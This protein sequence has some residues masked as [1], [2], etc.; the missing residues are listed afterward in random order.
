M[1]GADEGQAGSLPGGTLPA[2]PHSSFPPS[3]LQSR[4]SVPQAGRCP[5]SCAFVSPSVK[6]GRERGRVSG[7]LG[8][9][10]GPCGRC[11]CPV[12]SSQGAC[13]WVRIPPSVGQAGN[14]QTLGTQLALG[15]SF[16]SEWQKVIKSRWQQVRPS[17]WLPTA[18]VLST[19]WELIPVIPTA[20]PSPAIVSVV[21]T[22]R[23]RP[24]GGGQHGSQPGVP[25]CQPWRQ[26]DGRAPGAPADSRGLRGGASWLGS[27]RVS[28]LRS[29]A[30]C[31]VA[32]EWQGPGAPWQGPGSGEG[33]QGPGVEG[34]RE[35]FKEAVLCPG[36]RESATSHPGARGPGGWGRGGLWGPRALSAPD[37][38]WGDALL[39]PVV[40]VLRECLRLG[41]RKGP[42]Q[43]PWASSSHGLGVG[44]GMRPSCLSKNAPAQDAPRPTSPHLASP[45][46]RLWV[47]AGPPSCGLGTR[48]WEDWQCPVLYWALPAG[49]LQHRS[50]PQTGAQ[51]G[52]RPAYCAHSPR[53]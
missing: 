17:C 39:S 51:H 2:P 27:P 45:G 37:P 9:T 34:R 28:G 15:P 41:G 35:P 29:D 38:G 16:H 6:Q 3:E 21:Q 23:L 32:A 44:L 20:T 12:L 13:S 33:G 30:R 40:Q 47:E 26:T 10:Q 11:D 46:P 42:G 36:R 43:V 7:G 19:W 48:P 18:A 14:H 24:A 52:R 31:V 22:R 1:G 53:T 25:C 50:S 8:G 5:P 49:T 4:A